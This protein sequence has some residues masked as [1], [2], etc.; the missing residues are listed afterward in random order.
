MSNFKDE[1]LLSLYFIEIT[2]EAYHLNVIAAV[3][4]LK[5]V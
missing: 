5:N 4:N 1:K 2:G 3:G